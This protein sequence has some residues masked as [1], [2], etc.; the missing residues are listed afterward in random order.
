[1][2]LNRARTSVFMIAGL[3]AA[4]TFTCTAN[5]QTSE[6]KGAPTTV[7]TIHLSHATAQRDFNDLQTTLRNMIPAAVIYANVTQNTLSIRGTTEDIQTAR[8]LI[9]DL[10][11]PRKAWRVT[12]TF[13]DLENGKTA[14]VH[15]LTVVVISGEKA[16]VKRGN[17]MPIITG[18]LEKEGGA[19]SS[20]VQYLDVGLNVEASLDGDRL[21]SK[22]EQT[23]ISDEKSGIGAQ[24]PIVPQTLLEGTADLKPGKSF[25]L[26]SLDIPG[27]NRRED[28]EVVAE[29]VE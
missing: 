18:T 20:Q 22:L 24:D 9:S 10:D 8:R 14:G 5:A 13:T 23:A 16:I 1:M 2:N 6:S 4:L 7:E 17:R 11:Q 25:V 12:Y 3:A 28:I 26:G 27:T 15:R 19:Q 21:R 29:R